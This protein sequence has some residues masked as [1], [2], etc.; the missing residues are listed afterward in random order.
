MRACPWR[1][2]PAPREIPGEG[3]P[4]QTGEET[5]TAGLAAVLVAYPRRDHLSV[6]QHAGGFLLRAVRAVP[7]PGAEKTQSITISSPALMAG[8][9][10]GRGRPD[11][12]TPPARPTASTPRCGRLAGRRSAGQL[13]SSR[14]RP[15]SRKSQGKTPARG[16]M[17]R[18][19]PPCDSG[20]A[21]HARSGSPLQPPA[22]T[23]P[24][25]P[26]QLHLVSLAAARCRRI[27]KMAGGRGPHVRVRAPRCRCVSGTY[28]A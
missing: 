25:L 6:R 14:P 8:T 20:C 4:S 13:A 17:R 28:R 27:V 12:V 24:D 1:S 22:T 3:I 15:A 16:P 10:T 18:A 7:A 5:G 21:V 23:R 11:T 26:R 2:S 19:G 9:R